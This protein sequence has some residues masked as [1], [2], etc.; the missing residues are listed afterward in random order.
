MSCACRAM[1]PT[2]RPTTEPGSGRAR[3]PTPGPCASAAATPHACGRRLSPDATPA[4]ALPYEYAPTADAT[5]YCRLRDAEVCW[6]NTHRFSEVVANAPS[7][8]HRRRRV[9]KPGVRRSRWRRG[10]GSGTGRRERRQAALLRARGRKSRET[11]PRREPV[12][13][14][15]APARSAPGAGLT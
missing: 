1:Q 10:P 6:G 7:R 4:P 15:R 14:H 3:R 9:R 13:R 12:R 2:P 11:N 5:P 8:G